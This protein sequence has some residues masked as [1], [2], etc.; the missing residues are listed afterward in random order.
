MLLLSHRNMHT[1]FFSHRCIA[2]SEVCPFG[3]TFY[4]IC[5][6]SMSSPTPQIAA[7]NLQEDT[8]WETEFTEAINKLY[9]EVL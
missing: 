9:L 4:Y 2:G 5:K 7:A 1:L 3:P 8:M 6:S